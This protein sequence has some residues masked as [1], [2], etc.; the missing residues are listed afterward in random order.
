MHVTASLE[1]TSKK[2]VT[3][4]EVIIALDHANFSVS[5]GAMVSRYWS[6]KRAIFMQP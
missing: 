1:D 3:G 6:C 5:A 2:Y 4:Q